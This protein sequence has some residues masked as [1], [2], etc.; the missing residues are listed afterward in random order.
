MSALSLI[1][2]PL[3]TLLPKA[4][5]ARSP[6]N[7]GNLIDH[8]VGTAKYWHKTTKSAKLLLREAGA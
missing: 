3:I 2:A 1:S 8:K 7:T 4:F 6:E 5:L